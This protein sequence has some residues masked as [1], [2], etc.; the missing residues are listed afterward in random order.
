VQSGRFAELLA[1][2]GTFGELARRQM[3]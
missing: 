1:A 2:G 3:I